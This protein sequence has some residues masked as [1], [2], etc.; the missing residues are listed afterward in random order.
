VL[1]I[2]VPPGFK[3]RIRVRLSN[4]GRAQIC[5]IGIGRVVG[6]GRQVALL[7]VFWVIAAVV[8]RLDVSP[9][10]AGRRMVW[11]RNDYSRYRGCLLWD[12]GHASRNQCRYYGCLLRDACD[13]SGC[14]RRDCL[15]LGD[16]CK[17]AS[18]C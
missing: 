7:A 12:S 6:T 2:L 18:D 5:R 4:R 11:H 14:E 15:H 9:Q 13:V 3:R 10:G 16:V 17:G 1:R 8:R